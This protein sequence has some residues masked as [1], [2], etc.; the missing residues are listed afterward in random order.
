MKN[1]SSPK[2]NTT[3]WVK[4]QEIDI[5]KAKITPIATI[6]HHQLNSNHMTKKQFLEKSTFRILK[7]AIGQKEIKEQMVLV[8]AKSFYIQDRE[9]G[10]KIDSFNTLSEAQKAL[11]MYEEVD[12]ADGTYTPNFYE[13][14]EE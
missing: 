11:A 9:A 4:I 2:A 10:N 3:W 8:T 1:W 7:D 6:L 14:V 5:F 13:I 12:K